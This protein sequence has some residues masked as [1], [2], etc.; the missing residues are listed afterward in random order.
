M[1]QFIL[2]VPE[3]KARFFLELINSLGY[4][5]TEEVED[6]FA[7]EIPE[8][9]KQLVKDRIQTAKSSGILSW[10]EA[11]KKIKLG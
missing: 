11:A 7:F 9:Q 6:A 4:I 8:E 1:K 2:Q 3:K 10:D 5:K